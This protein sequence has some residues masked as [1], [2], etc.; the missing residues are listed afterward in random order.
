MRITQHESHPFFQCVHRLKVK[1]VQNQIKQLTKLGTRNTRHGT[2]AL[3]QL[4]H[5]LKRSTSADN[6]F[7]FYV[8]RNADYHSPLSTTKVENTRSVTST[9]QYVFRPK[10]DKQERNWKIYNL[11][12][13]PR[14]LTHVVSLTHEFIYLLVYCSTNDAFRYWRMPHDTHISIKIRYV[15]Q[16]IKNK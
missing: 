9:P 7:D 3:P 10:Q 1:D 16:I 2:A 6:V 14:A 15:R 13:S 12:N 5:W 8:A 11:Q 4:S